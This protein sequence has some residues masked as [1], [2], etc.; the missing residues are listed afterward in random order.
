MYDY[1]LRTKIY[2]LCILIFHNNSV[3]EVHNLLFI[4]GYNDILLVPAGATN[5]KIQEIDAVS[6][7]LGEYFKMILCPVTQVMGPCSY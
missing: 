6:N 2:I 5:I 7:Y 4:S 1:T 3:L